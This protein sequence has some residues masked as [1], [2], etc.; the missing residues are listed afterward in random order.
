M[1]Q[2]WS[3]L[4][5]NIILAVFH[6]LLLNAVDAVLSIYS[7]FGGRYANSIRWTSQGGYIEMVRA[8]WNS[9]KS[10]TIS[11]KISMAIAIVAC[12]VASLASSGAALFIRPAGRLIN[13]NSTVFKVPHYLSTNIEASFLQWQSAIHIGNNITDAIVRMTNDSNVIL[14]PEVGRIYTPRTAEYEV[15]CSNLGLIWGFGA[16][17]EDIPFTRL[18]SGDCV[19]LMVQSSG[20][21]PIYSNMSI[22]SVHNGRWSITT[23]YGYLYKG[24]LYEV[25]TSTQIIYGN[26]SLSVGQSDGYSFA[27]STT[28]ELIREPTTN[29]AKYILSTGATVSL[30]MTEVRFISPNIQKFLNNSKAIFGETDDLFQAMELS[31]NKNKT[32]ASSGAS[33][34]EIIISG[35]ALSSLSCYSGISPW[36]GNETSLMCSYIDVRA[37]V[38]KPQPISPVISEARNGRPLSDNTF[39]NQMIQLSY[40][41]DNINGIVQPIPLLS[42]KQ[43]TS[44]AVHYMASLGQNLYLDWDEGQLYV[45]FDTVDIENGFEIQIWLVV[46][47]LSLAIVSV[48]LW[49]G[50][51]YFLD[52]AYKGSLY[53]NAS[54]EMGKQANKKAPMLMSFDAHSMEMEDTPIISR[55]NIIHQEVDTLI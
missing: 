31:I 11:T 41:P 15:A 49:G 17:D 27:D 51:W 37:I 43:A 14:E 45:I 32:M 21:H 13:A 8:L 6:L 3:V 44:A 23:P 55:D 30:S 19:I 26:R 16:D 28:E 24:R 1:F 47:V 2:P 42:L 5:V 22:T 48:C 52:P 36:Q 34:A 33:F 54:M 18:S 46:A 38:T 25:T 39:P 20:F 4:V 9:R 40:I 12:L 10:L 35:S 7:R 50:A 53:N 29:V